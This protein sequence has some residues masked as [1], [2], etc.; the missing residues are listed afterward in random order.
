[1]T[2]LWLSFTIFVICFIFFLGVYRRIIWPRLWPSRGRWTSTPLTPA[3]LPGR[4]SGLIKD[5]VLVALCDP[6]VRVEMERAL[7]PRKTPRAPLDL[8]WV[9]WALI[10][11]V[12]TWAV[13]VGVQRAHS[14]QFLCTPAQGAPK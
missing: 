9:I 11:L 5:G 7:N 1:M 14:P 2:N 6:E 12:T 4:S 8:P 10:L 3:Q 13:L